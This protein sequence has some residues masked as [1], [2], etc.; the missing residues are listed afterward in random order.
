MPDPL[1]EG[2]LSMNLPAVFEVG[3][4]VRDHML[5]RQPKDRDFMVCGLSAEELLSTCRQQGLAEELRV[6]DQLVGVRLRAPFTPEEGVE[7]ALARTEV[8]TG[9]K[10]SDFEICPLEPHPDIADLPITE[11]HGHPSLQRQLLEDL[12]RRDFTCNAIARNI[13]TGE[14]VDPLGGA[15]AI[16]K[17]RLQMVSKQAFREDPLRILRGLGRISIDGLKPSEETARLAMESAPSIASVSGER[18]GEELKKILSGSHSGAALRTA[19]DWGALQAALPELEE[20][21][22]FEQQSRYHALTVDEHTFC[23]LD[24]ADRLGLDPE[25]KLAI[26]FHD[27]GKPRTAKPKKGGGM[28]YH[29]AEKS[30]SLWQ[31]DP[32]R[33]S[34]HEKVGAELFQK[35]A[36]RLGFSGKTTERVSGLIEHHMFGAEQG[37]ADKSEQRQKLSSRKMLAKHGLEQSQDLVRV[38]ICDR[39]GKERHP[40]PGFDQDARRLMEVLKT[41]SVNPTSIPELSLKG[42]DLLDMGL[43]PGPEVGEVLE[44]LLKIVVGEPRENDPERLR[45]HA[46]RAIEQI[47]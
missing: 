29:A 8:S 34:A 10:H 24:Q 11:R 13:Q 30:D 14:I 37:F 1:A 25:I 12:S 36:D 3:G 40:Q 21:I 47:S 22:G 2:M 43:K 9:P 7:V 18:V 20:M 45:G 4:A 42:D 38:R 33:A 26:L 28:M 35:A 46:K 32:Q 41:E 6:A 15:E 39:A 17:G 31:S 19:R 16:S 27:S 23:A 5:G 44:R